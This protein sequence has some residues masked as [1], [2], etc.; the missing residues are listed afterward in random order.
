MTSEKRSMSLWAMKLGRSMFIGG[1]IRGK[2][3]G[4]VAV[5][6][7]VDEVLAGTDGDALALE[8]V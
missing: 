2:R 5:V 8:K 4:T 6:G 1:V 3:I 7:R